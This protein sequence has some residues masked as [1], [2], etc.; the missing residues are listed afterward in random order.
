MKAA[1]TGVFSVAVL[2]GWIYTRSIYT[3]EEN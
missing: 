1:A 3:V 2:G